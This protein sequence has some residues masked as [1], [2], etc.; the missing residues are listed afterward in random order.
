[1]A[2]AAGQGGHVRRGGA[3]AVG[4]SRA[5]AMG[6]EVSTAH[7][8]PRG[9]MAPRARRGATRWGPAAPLGPAALGAQH[10]RGEGMGPRAPT[11]SGH[12][13]P[14][15]SR[16]PCVR[17]ETAFPWPG[18]CGSWGGGA[19][20]RRKGDPGGSPGRPRPPPR[21][22]PRP[23]PRPLPAPAAPPLERARSG[24]GWARLSPRGAASYDDIPHRPP[25]LI[26]QR[27]QREG[28]GKKKKKLVFVV[29]IGARTQDLRI[30]Q[31]ELDIRYLPRL[32][33]ATSERRVTTSFLGFH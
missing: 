15:R 2:R 12:A 33:T 24:G 11:W 28:G 29:E 16:W 1:M 17:S 23:H 21:P 4:A 9:E 26:S 31:P 18:S 27:F 3:G 14:R 5:R 22:R 25:D 6:K 19:W 20:E 32:V 8:R 10:P 30:A 13:S 7:W